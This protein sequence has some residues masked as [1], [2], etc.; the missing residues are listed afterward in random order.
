MSSAITLVCY[1]SI[2]LFTTL[3]EAIVYV[4]SNASF[5][6]NITSTCSSALMANLSCPEGLERLRQGLYYPESFL[7]SLCTPLCSSALASYE[8]DVEGAC[9]DEAYDSLTGLGDVPLYTIP[10]LLRYFYNY[11]CLSDSGNGQ[12]CNVESANSIGVAANQS[13]LSATTSFFDPQ[14][15]T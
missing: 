5:P 10:Q 14:D 8:L 11:T 2:I 9:G 6:A 13:N 4:Q 1:G 3:V 15:E 12:Y 7:S